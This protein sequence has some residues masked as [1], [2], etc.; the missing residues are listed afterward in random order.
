MRKLDIF[1]HIMPP[2]YYSRLMSLAPHFADVGKRMRN[3]PMLVDI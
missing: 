1:T 3:V 2:A